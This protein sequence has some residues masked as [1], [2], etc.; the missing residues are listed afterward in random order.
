[1]NA[2]G[3]RV[4]SAQL[5]L[6]G[7]RPRL[8]ARRLDQL[9]STVAGLLGVAESQ[10]AVVASSGNLAGAEG[11]GLVISASASVTLVR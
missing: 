11:A 10:L 7:A 2:D 6:L 5:S 1:V 9:R 8:G 3:W 4:L